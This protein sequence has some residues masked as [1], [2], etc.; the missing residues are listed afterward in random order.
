M[1]VGFYECDITPPLGCDMPGYYGQ[2][3]AKD[4][5]ERLYAK[6]CVIEENGTYAA[7]LTLDTCE[8][9]DAMTKPVTDRVFE[10]T[11]I[12][13]ESIC[14]H[15]VHTHKGAPTEH[16]PEVGQCCDPI[17]TDVCMRRAADAIILAY[18]RLQDGVEARFGCGNVEG[19]SFNRN[20]VVEGGEIRSFGPGKKKM[21]GTLAGI[22]P[23]LPILTF[24]KDGKPIGAIIS[25]ACHQ[26]CTGSQVNGYSA[27]YSGILAMEL[28]KKYGPEFVSVFLIGTAG[29][30]NHISNAPTVKRPPFWYREMGRI[31]AREAERVID[32]ELKPVGE[33]VGVKKEAIELPVRTIDLEESCRQIGKWAEKKSM[34]RLLNLAYYYTTNTADHDSLWLQ[35]I[36]VGKACIY[37]MA[38]EI[39][40]NFGLRLKNES[41]FEYNM[42]VENSNSFGGYIPTTEAFAEESDL[43]EISLCEGSRHAPEAGDMMVK[44][45]LEMSAEL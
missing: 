7:I 11:G 24:F 19:I 14:I 28:K 6:A 27:D 23:Q 38:G 21:I 2:N 15:V 18:K 39:Y 36:R 43:Y 26:D 41:P 29:D 16:R 30:I 22:D 44:R 25:F 8:Y 32:N 42:V 17:Y 13:A 5:Y 3:I 37:V 4:V 33:G 35:V 31:I 1:R 10:Y 20:Y 12:P 45:L 34:M 40:V 9:V